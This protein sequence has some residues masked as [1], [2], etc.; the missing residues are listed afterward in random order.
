MA[1]PGTDDELTR[2][3]RN[4]LGSSITQMTLP[5]AAKILGI[6]GRSLQRR[7]AAR[8]LSYREIQRAMRCEV[9]LAMLARNESTASQVADSL[10][11]SELSSFSR[12]FKR[13]TGLSPRAHRR[14]LAD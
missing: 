14:R 3:L 8:G 11:F 13:W 9:A 1:R 7:L 12:A 4:A 6:S 5:A 2:T 10:G